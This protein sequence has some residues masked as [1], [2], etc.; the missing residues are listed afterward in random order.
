MKHDI[1]KSD[2]YNMNKKKFVMNIINNFKVLIQ[3]TEAQAFS[4]YVNN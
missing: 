1:F 2:I 3:Y 4:V